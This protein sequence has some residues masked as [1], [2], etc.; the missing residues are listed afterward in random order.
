MAKQIDMILINIGQLLTMESSGPRTGKSMQDLH[1]IEDAVIGIDNQKIVFAGKKGAEAEYAAAD[2]IDCGGRLVTPGLVDPHTHLVFGGSREKELNL[3][4]Q[5]MSY[6]DILSQGG[7]ILSTVKH[8]REAS[9]EDLLQKGHFHLK[10]MLSYGTTTAEVKSGYGLEK[11][12]EFKQLRVAKKLH[13]SQPI[14]LVSTFM[15]AHAIP[16]EDKDSPDEFLDRMLELL[17]E[18]KEKELAAFADIFT[19]TG[20]FTVSQSR[21]Y[22]KKAAEAGFGLKIHADEIDPLGGAELAAELRAVSADH[23]VGA[24]DEG[25]QQMAES[26]TIAVLLPG[27]TFYL[28]KHT[29]ARA[30]DMIDAGVRVSLATDFNPGSS[31]TENIQLIMSIAALHLK[32]TAE[33]IW[34][35]VTVN[36]AYA[37]G[38]GEEAGQLKPGRTADLVIWEAPNYMYI[39]YHYG[40]NH[41][42]QVIKDGK[43]VISR[44]GAVLG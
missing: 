9:E 14:D 25:I 6:L 3:K 24:S 35:A 7:G 34:H 22:L 23:L 27:T 12:T 28:G 10:R 31:P 36:A 38:K 40:V 32:M 43:L 1:V 20:V 11:E 37:I 5:G 17:P 44:E 16:P 21:R 39:P 41:V 2:I 13:E 29:Y 8:T 33:E 30:R 4:I 15:G 26:G 18:I 42:H 19:E